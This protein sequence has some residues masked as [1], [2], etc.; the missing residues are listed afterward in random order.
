MEKIIRIENKDGYGFESC[1]SKI[2]QNTFD[3]DVR[4]GFTR[5]YYKFGGHFDNPVELTTIEH[6]QLYIAVT[7]FLDILPL[8]TLSK[9]LISVTDDGIFYRFKTMPEDTFIKELKKLGFTMYVYYV[10][11]EYTLKHQKFNSNEITFLY[12][13]DDKNKLFL[14][15]ELYKPK[16]RKVK[17]VKPL[18]HVKWNISNNRHL[19]L[20]YFYG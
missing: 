9:K 10:P 12:Q 2:R 4:F 7:Q 8:Y 20:E 17:I 6:I 18:K 14:K 19:K 13:D 1:V 11:K 16:K 3:S 15:K 5:C